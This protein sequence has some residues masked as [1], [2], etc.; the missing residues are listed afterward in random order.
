[1]Q[2]KDK[3]QTTILLILINFHYPLYSFVTIQVII[4]TFIFINY[5]NKLNLEKSTFNKYSID[6][7]T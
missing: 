2:K 1:M 7:I 4:A 6:Y 5:L 3:I